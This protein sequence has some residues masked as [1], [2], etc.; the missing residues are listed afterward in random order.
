[1]SLTGNSNFYDSIDMKY[2]EV[3][4]LMEDIPLPKLPTLKELIKIV[5]GKDDISITLS[6]APFRAEELY[7]D[8]IGKFS[9]PI[10]FPAETEIKDKKMLA[11]SVMNLK[12]NANMV[13]SNYIS[14][15]YIELNIPKY[16]LLNF[17][18]LVPKG[19]RFLLCF[20]GGSIGI[21]DIRVI[22]VSEY[23]D[24]DK[25]TEE[26]DRGTDISGI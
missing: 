20:I 15:N 19:T 5:K 23:V 4:I 11:P 2:I 18:G 9:I 24:I 16:I 26:Q 25:T 10:L 7:T 13:T 21:E 22:G 3:G 12:N 8:M 17:K 14:S 6:S 1:M